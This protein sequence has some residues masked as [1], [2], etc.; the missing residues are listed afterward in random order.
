MDLSQSKDCRT[1]YPAI[2]QLPHDLSMDE[3]DLS[4]SCPH[5]PTNRQDHGEWKKLNPLGGFPQ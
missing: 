1:G 3:D 2:G 4:P 5:Y